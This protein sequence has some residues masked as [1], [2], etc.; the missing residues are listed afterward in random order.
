M[1]QF[2]DGL[3]EV[4]VRADEQRSLTRDTTVEEMQRIATR[5]EEAV[6]AAAAGEFGFTVEEAEAAEAESLAEREWLDGEE[7][8][9]APDAESSEPAE[10]ASG[11]PSPGHLP[12][13][14]PT[15][16]PPAQPRRRLRRGGDAAGRQRNQQPTRLATR[17]AATSDVAAGAP[18][19]AAAT[20][21]GSSRATAT[22]P[23]KRPRGPTPPPRRAEGGPDF[24]LSA[25]SSDK[26]EE[27]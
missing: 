23:A 3:V 16:Q 11:P 13:A 21:A 1:Q 20:G 17:S 2:F 15:A 8:L 6:A 25:L 18:R 10:G 9:A 12:Q 14:E 7:E 24:D 19:T 26:E 27:E 4:A 22:A 5:A